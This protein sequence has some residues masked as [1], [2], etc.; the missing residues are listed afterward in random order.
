MPLIA[1]MAANDLRLRQRD[2]SALITAFVAPFALA[3]LISLAVGPGGEGLE[4]KIG[5][6]DAD[7][8]PI[9]REPDGWP[10]E[11]IR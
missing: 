4:A 8:S 7:G 2:R 11:P 1:V 3:A 10:A 5:V 9:S 6:V